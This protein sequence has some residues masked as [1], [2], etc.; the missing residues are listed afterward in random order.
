MQ[1]SDPSI[2]GPRTML[3]ADAGDPI[4]A[5]KH[6]STRLLE[7]FKDPDG[8]LYWKTCGA[9]FVNP[10]IG[11]VAVKAPL[12]NMP[13]DLSGFDFEFSRCQAGTRAWSADDHLRYLVGFS[14]KGPHPF[15]P[16]IKEACDLP[17]PSGRAPV[18]ESIEKSRLVLWRSEPWGCGLDRE[19]ILARFA[20]CAGE[21]KAQLAEGL[22]D[23]MQ[24]NFLDPSSSRFKRQCRTALGLL[25]LRCFITEDELAKGLTPFASVDEQVS[26]LGFMPNGFGEHISKLMC[27]RGGYQRSWDIAFCTTM[28]AGRTTVASPRPESMYDVTCWSQHY[29]MNLSQTKELLLD[30]ISSSK[31]H[32]R[33]G[34]PKSMARKLRVRTPSPSRRMK[35]KMAEQQGAASGAP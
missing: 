20:K 23:A 25:E 11:G 15:G 6:F 5:Y 30:E 35:A 2:F 28:H 21:A 9:S 27:Y 8:P 17:E 29:P 13:A 22:G 24:E 12:V 32:W 16:I 1:A 4:L 26:V 19:A 18:C 34:M 33:A 14:E 7:A 31:K 10:S 3:E